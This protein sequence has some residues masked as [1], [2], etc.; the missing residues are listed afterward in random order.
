MT[1]KIIGRKYEKQ[2]LQKGFESKDAEF[3]A[4]YGRRRV[5]KTFLVRNFFSSKKCIFFQVT[6][7][8]QAALNTQ[9]KEFKNEIERAFFGETGG[10]HLKEPENWMEAFDLLTNTIQILKN[11]KKVVLFFDEFPWMATPKSGL[12]QALD[13]HWNRFWVNNPKIK[14]IICGS[15]A[16]W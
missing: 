9:L 13:Y 16:S 14:L 5:G 10:L 8:H 3:I 6:G 15:A 1:D 4:V 7:I 2:R 11:R 12:L